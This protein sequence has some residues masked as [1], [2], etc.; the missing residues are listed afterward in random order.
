MET[1]KKS[2][3]N[4][5]QAQLQTS[6]PLSNYG[7]TPVAENHQPPFPSS[8][9]LEIIPCTSKDLYSLTTKAASLAQ[10][11]SPDDANQRELPRC[12][13]NTSTQNCAIPGLSSINGR[14]P[15][16]PDI[17]ILDRTTDASSPFLTQHR[18]AQHQLRQN[19]ITFPPASRYP[20]HPKLTTFQIYHFPLT[21]ASHL[22]ESN[23]I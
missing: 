16:Q 5:R 15:W 11:S 14:S 6:F 17:T 10:P 23:I 4:N 9:E 2:V 13:P 19:L 12:W 8:P 21:K 3:A 18:Y 20:S 22:Q 1:I 7:K